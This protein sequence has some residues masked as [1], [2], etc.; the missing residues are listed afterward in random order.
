MEIII[1]ESEAE[2]VA[3]VVA[4]V[5]KTIREQPESVFGLSTSA[6]LAKVYAELAEAHRRDGLSF[7]RLTTF[8]LG[9]YIG[10][11][12]DDEHSHWGFMRR[13][14]FDLV[15]IDETRTHLLR[16]DAADVE[17]ECDRYEYLLQ[18]AGGIDVQLLGL[19][20]TGH[21]GFN[22]ASL[23][24]NERTHARML[25]PEVSGWRPPRSPGGNGEPKRVITMGLGTILESRRCVVLA[26]GEE[27][28]AVVAKAMEGPLTSMLSASA[29]Q[30][31]PRCTV[32]IDRAASQC[33][34]GGDYY[35][36]IYANEPEWRE[37]H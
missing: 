36:W 4:L 1:R 25:V 7:S 31:H 3:L 5:A 35:D 12:P 22:A 24:M 18:Q 2:A 34:E 10:V 30:L 6:T 16:G 19:S 15:D 11:K 37:F 32:V 8:N 20:K 29:L 28:A 21:I 33:L 17:A 14:F 9:E 26:T 27:K 23:E 13:H